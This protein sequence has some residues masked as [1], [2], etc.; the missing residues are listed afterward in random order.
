MSKEPL[1]SDFNPVSSKEYKQKIQYDLKGADYNETLVW[2]SDEGINVKPFYHR[3]ELE[4]IQPIPGMPQQWYIGEAI[5]ILDARQSAETA[6]RAINDGAEAIYFQADTPFDVETLF[7]SLDSKEVP[8]YFNLNFLDVDFY[9][10]VAAFAK[11]RTNTSSSASATTIK[12]DLIHHLVTDGNWYHTLT[13][14]HTIFNKLLLG[15]TKNITIDTTAYQNAGATMFQQ[16]AYGLAHLN[17]YL[18][19]CEQEHLTPDEVTFEVA[20]GTNYFF[21][22]AKLR[23]IRKLVDI[24]MQE[25]ALAGGLGEA[26]AKTKLKIIAHPT[27]RNKTIYDYNINML[28]TT[29]ECMSAVLG[30]ADW[31]VNLP[32]DALYHKTNNFGQRIARNQLIVM[33]EESYLDAVSN[34][35]DGAYY[36]EELTRQLAEKALI[37]F[38]DIESNGGFLKQ[39]KEGTIQRKIKESAAREQEQFD[40]GDITLLGTNKHP[41]PNDKMKDDLELFPFLKIKPRKTI[42]EPIIPRRLAEAFEQERLKT[43]S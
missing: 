29:T 33:K 6:N 16:L 7:S 23:A 42:I 34:P 36:V 12:L 25:Y 40:G 26:F 17:E 8:V 22:I 20:I 1:F 27:R 14:D 5:F 21:E 43:E 9:E 2:H 38:K 30:G 41:N 28:R 35:A 31:V 19:H 24:L 11:A 13:Q 18:N 32:Y 15:S 3:D 39:L 37:L 10:H 4:N